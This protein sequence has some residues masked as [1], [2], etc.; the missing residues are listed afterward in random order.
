MHRLI[1][2]L[3]LLPLTLS[4]CHSDASVPEGAGDALELHLYHVAPQQT[5]R[6][7]NALNQAL[8]SGEHGHIGS[9]SSPGDGQL[10]VL[11]PAA[12]QSSIAASIKAFAPVPAAP[13]RR[14]RV[15]FWSVDAI[16]GKGDDG[17]GLE[18]VQPALAQ[19]R[20]LLGAMHFVLHDSAGIVSTSD[21]GEARSE[22]SAADANAPTSRM[23]T[24]TYRLD[25]S[26]D[27]LLLHFQYSDAIPAGVG[28]RH[29]RLTSVDTRTTVAVQLNQLLVL[30]QIPLAAVHDAKAQAA[31]PTMRLY[32]IRVTSV[33]AA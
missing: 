4:G 33:P 18:P 27:G 23:R 12:L 13:D 3:A 22:W 15:Q 31:A 11:A 24:L 28:D 7:R 29:P 2:L 20:R 1:F 9:V 30:A 19:A 6:L 17:A 10:M 14:L 5:E 25:Q 26:G 16:P 21:R 32:I 8:A